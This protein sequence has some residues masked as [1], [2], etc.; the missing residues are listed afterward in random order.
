MT[1]NRF[2]SRLRLVWVLF[3]LVSVGLSAKDYTV[4]TVPNVRLTDRLNHVSNPDNILSPIAVAQINGMLGYLEDSLGIEVA[5]VALSGIGDVPPREFANELFN[6]WHI[7]KAGSDNGLLMQLVTSP[8]KRTIVFETGYGIEAIL[9]DALC[10]RIQQRHMIPLLRQDDY[11]GGMVAGV[12]AVCQHFFEQVTEKTEPQVYEPIAL[13]ETARQIL[14]GLGLIGMA[15]SAYGVYWAVYGSLPRCPRCGRQGYKRKEYTSIYATTT[16]EG[17]A[18]IE[19]YCM[20]C[21]YSKK[22]TYAT[23]LLG[24][25]SYYGYY[26]DGMDSRGHSS[27]HGGYH[28]G[29][30]SGDSD[31]ESAGSSWGGGSSGGGGACSSF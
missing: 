16:Q 10:K 14:I 19:H 3:L 7:G 29:W 13:S 2:F 31:S 27:Y 11:S 30:S 20:H 5:V 28:S 12:E 15:L 21:G 17:E 18:T 6:Y 8:G 25:R 22:E 1:F 23:P 4:E 24:N 9:P 26:D